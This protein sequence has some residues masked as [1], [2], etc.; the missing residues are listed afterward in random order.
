MN[1]NGKTAETI[2]KTPKYIA[3][4]E[5]CYCDI[6]ERFKVSTGVSAAQAIKQTGTEAR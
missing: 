6:C 5:G 1:T 3:S 4:G 2:R